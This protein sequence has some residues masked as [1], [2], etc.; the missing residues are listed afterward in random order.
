MKT[1]FL[2]PPHSRLPKGYNHK[3]L[4]RSF[5]NVH[6]TLVE[7]EKHSTW[8]R[9]R[10]EGLSSFVSRFCTSSEQKNS[11]K[12]KFGPGILAAIC[13]TLIEIFGR[14]S[15]HRA[16]PS[17]GL[18]RYVLDS[19]QESF[20]KGNLKRGARC[21]RFHRTLPVVL[22]DEMGVRYNLLGSDG[23]FVRGSIEPFG[24]SLVTLFFSYSPR[25]GTL[26]TH[27]PPPP[28]PPLPAS[29]FRV[30]TQNRHENGSK[31]TETL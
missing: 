29:R 16:I 24:V 4:G 12:S 22:K 6:R 8:C 5:P 20:K 10:V 3:L 18:R 15:I 21:Q 31:I 25:F 17:D 2:E 14:P 23:N 9:P 30:A 1:P 28:T 19:S 7:N 26:G 27:P 13:S 11:P